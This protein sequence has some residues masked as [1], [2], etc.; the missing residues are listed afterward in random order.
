M[1][2][3]VIQRQI[4]CITFQNYFNNKHPN[5]KLTCVCNRT[6]FI[7]RM[8]SYTKKNKF[9][10]IA[11]EASGLPGKINYISVTLQ[12][13]ITSYYCGRDTMPMQSAEKRVGP[14]H[15]RTCNSHLSTC[16]TSTVLP[17]GCSTPLAGLLSDKLI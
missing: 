4:P 17:L 10:V 9:N 11:W 7:S 15:A 16:W 14:P 6:F 2:I 13:L 1:L 8:F 3:F 12:K 5:I